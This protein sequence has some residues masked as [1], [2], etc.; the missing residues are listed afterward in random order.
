MMRESAI[1]GILGIYTLGFYID[2]AISDDQIDKA[3]LLILMTALL[4]MGIDSVSQQ[5]RRRLKISTK[6]V[7]SS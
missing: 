6:L 4:N 3:I 2:S 1:L 7:T 5:V